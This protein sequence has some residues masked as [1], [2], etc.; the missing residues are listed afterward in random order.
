MM[1]KSPGLKRCEI[2]DRLHPD[3]AQPL[4]FLG[5]VDQRPEAV[6]LALVG[7]VKGRVDRP[8]HAEAEPRLIS[9]KYFHSPSLHLCPI[10]DSIRSSTWSMLMVLESIRERIFGLPERRDRSPA[11]LLVTLLDLLSDP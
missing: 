6:Y 2:L 8:F 4:N 1:R 10:S 5:I 7:G 3:L 9:Q 11:V